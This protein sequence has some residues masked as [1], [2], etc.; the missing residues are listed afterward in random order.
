MAKIP[1]CE[2]CGSLNPPSEWPDDM[3]DDYV[4]ELCYKC[5]RQEQSMED[6]DEE[7]L[8]TNNNN[9]E[10]VPEFDPEESEVPDA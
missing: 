2:K 10:D 6:E 4:P 8:S 9:D 1:I 7:D 5:F 3:A